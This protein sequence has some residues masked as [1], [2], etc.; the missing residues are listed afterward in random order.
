MEQQYSK[1]SENNTH[2]ANYRGIKVLSDL[3]KKVSTDEKEEKQ[4]SYPIHSVC[5]VSGHLAVSFHDGRQFVVFDAVPLQLQLSDIEEE[6]LRRFVLQEVNDYLKSILAMKTLSN[7]IYLKFMQKPKLQLLAVHSD[8]TLIIWHWNQLRYLWTYKVRKIIPSPLSLSPSQSHSNNSKQHEKER[9]GILSFCSVIRSPPHFVKIPNLNK[10]ESKLEQECIAGFEHLMFPQQIISAQTKENALYFVTIDYMLGIEEEQRIKSN[11][12]DIHR[13]LLRASFPGIA[14]QKTLSTRFIISCHRVNETFNSLKTKTLCDSL[15]EIEFWSDYYSKTNDETMRRRVFMVVENV[16]A[17]KYGFIIEMTVR[18]C[19]ILRKETIASMMSSDSNTS[20]QRVFNVDLSE[21]TI[22]KRMFY[23]ISPANEQMIRIPFPSTKCTE[24]QFQYHKKRQHHQ[25]NKLNEQNL[26]NLNDQKQ[27]NSFLSKSKQEIMRFVVGQ[28]GTTK[29]LLLLDRLDASF[30]ILDESELAKSSLSEYEH[31]FHQNQK[32]QIEKHKD[33]LSERSLDALKPKF[34]LPFGHFSDKSRQVKWTYICR[35]DLPSD[36]WFDPTRQIS[37][38][39]ISKRYKA[40][41]E[42]FKIWGYRDWICC[43]VLFDVHSVHLTNIALHRRH[44]FHKYKQNQASEQ[45]ADN[46]T[47][48]L[49]FPSPIYTS[50]LYKKMNV[51]TILKEDEH[52]IKFSKMCALPK[53]VENGSDYAIIHDFGI[54][55]KDLIFCQIVEP[56]YA[57]IEAVNGCYFPCQS[58]LGALNFLSRWGANT[59]TLRGKYLI[60]FL[61]QQSANN[62]SIQASQTQQALKFAPFPILAALLHKFRHFD[63]L[64]FRYYKMRCDEYPKFSFNFARIFGKEAMENLLHFMEHIHL[65]QAPLPILSQNMKK[66]VKKMNHSPLIDKDLAILRGEVSIDYDAQSGVTMYVRNIVANEEKKQNEEEEKEEEVDM[67]QI[68]TL[69]CSN[70]LSDLILLEKMLK[71]DGIREDPFHAPT[72]CA[73]PQFLCRILLLPAS[74][75]SNHDLEITTPLNLLSALCR[76]YDFIFPAAIHRLIEILCH[77]QQAT[78]NKIV[79]STLQ[80]LQNVKHGLTNLPKIG[81]IV[82]EKE[83]IENEDAFALFEARIVARVNLC[84]IGNLYFKMLH[85][86]L[87]AP[88]TLRRLDSAIRASIEH[89]ERLTPIQRASK[90]AVIKNLPKAEQPKAKPTPKESKPTQPKAKTTPMQKAL[91][92]WWSSQRSSSH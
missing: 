33:K 55:T 13:Y 8:G 15:E 34:N 24:K 90:E 28:H 9:P 73:N 72:F 59:L 36:A 86:L 22:E 75:R 32:N 41:N 31:S 11:V 45:M 2:F 5:S 67:D 48:R 37:D 23:Y 63:A 43:N 61:L 21:I 70:S 77:F 1:V 26:N 62:D 84:K 60:D 74:F 10:M 71:L 69:I 53:D 39:C 12:Y 27:A 92:H 65:N 3:F 7:V 14:S 49:L 78:T 25:K 56:F 91:R 18:R 38:E 57:Q 16:F 66:K 42:E 17:T 20:S 83:E 58:V 89:K 88:L 76:F 85:H 54:F 40:K 30:Y 46:K 6:K 35:F 29:Q 51:S 82:D 80:S 47:M 52:Q 50:P 79:M 19:N 64:L 68:R 87:S 44:S 81:L 4:S